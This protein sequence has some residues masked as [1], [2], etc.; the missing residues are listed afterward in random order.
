MPEQ[1]AAAQSRCGVLSL[2]K[3]TASGCA[4]H[5]GSRSGPPA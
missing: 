4:P 3:S 1:V 2:G 5:S